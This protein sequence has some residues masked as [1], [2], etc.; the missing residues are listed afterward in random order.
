MDNFMK[1]LIPLFPNCAVCGDSETP[2][3][4]TLGAAVIYL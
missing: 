1:M 2:V 3:F 4:V